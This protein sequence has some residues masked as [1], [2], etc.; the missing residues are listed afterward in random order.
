[1]NLQYR[2]GQWMLACFGDAI[3]KDKS[4]RNHRFLEE[5][6][7]L[8]QACGASKDEALLLVDYVYGRPLGEPGQEVGGVLLTLSALCNARG[9]DMD[10]AGER[11]I[12]R[13]DTP[14]M[15]ARIRQKQ[16]TK[17]A[18]SPLPGDAA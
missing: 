6:L 8:A 17:P 4:E 5:A 1:M 18:S 14:E 11:E 13:V 3:A 16:A 7:E 9:I 12:E 15:I 10:R 2:V